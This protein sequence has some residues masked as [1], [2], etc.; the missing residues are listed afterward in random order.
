MPQNL[1]KLSKDLNHDILILSFDFLFHV[2]QRSVVLDYSHPREQEPW[3]RGFLRGRSR[4]IALW[5]FNSRCVEEVYRMAGR[6]FHGLL[7]ASV[8]MVCID[9]RSESQIT[10]SFD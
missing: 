5:N 6:G 3:A 1:V 7:C 10:S 4:R 2:D 8:Y 9:R